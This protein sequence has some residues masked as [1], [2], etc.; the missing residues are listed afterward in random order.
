MCLSNNIVKDGKPLYVLCHKTK[1][2]LT[3]GFTA[4]KDTIYSI[5][6]FKI[7][8]L[9]TKLTKIGIA[10]IGV[11]TDCI[12]F[13]ESQKSLLKKAKEANIDITF[14]KMI[15]KTHSWINVIKEQ[16]DDDD[17]HYDDDDYDNNEK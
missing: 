13:N 5:Q 11:K 4:I 17:H 8:Q 2:N 10:P 3:E 12:L 1:M 7:W 15:K 16:N 6:R 14:D 9:Y